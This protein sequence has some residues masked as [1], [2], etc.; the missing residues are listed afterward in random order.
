MEQNTTETKSLFQKESDSPVRNLKAIFE[1]ILFVAKRP[2]TIKD[3]RKICPDD[4]RIKESE[5]AALIEEIKVEYIQSGRSFR[6]IEIANGYQMRTSPDYAPHIARFFQLNKAENLSQPALETLA[7]I[8]YRQP[9]TKAVIEGVR[10]VDSS[11]VIKS[12]YE[13]GLIKI[14]GRLEVPGRPFIYATTKK[15]LEHFGLKTV[16]DLPHRN[17][18]VVLNT[19]QK[20]MD[21]SAAK[22]NEEKTGKKTDRNKEQPP[23]GGESAEDPQGEG[24]QA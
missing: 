24:E 7:V 21:F 15:F 12:L 4:A 22:D 16:E 20:T 1:A 10:G 5:I 2:V 17:E 14:A 18:L 8:A 23:V 13:K 11:G 19:E 3:L 6:I 9:I